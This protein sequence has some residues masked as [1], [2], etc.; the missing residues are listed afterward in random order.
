MIEEILW[1]NDRPPWLLTFNV[2]V[3]LQSM[4]SLMMISKKQLFI[5]YFC[6]TRTN[7]QTYFLV[8]FLTSLMSITVDA[9]RLYN[10]RCSPTAEKE[11][12]QSGM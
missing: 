4:S 6:Q 10:R 5:N 2:T 12:D 1:H 8:V 11:K 7:I 3:L 9:Y